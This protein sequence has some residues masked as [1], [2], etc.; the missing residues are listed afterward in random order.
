MLLWIPQ[1]S[2]VRQS[3][4]E[5]VLQVD[6]RD[7]RLLQPGDVVFISVPTAFWAVLASNW[8]LPEYR[9]GHV[10]MVSRA[11]PG[12]LAV[13]HASGNPTLANA[14]VIAVPLAEFVEGASRVDIFRPTRKSAALGSAA[15]AD[16]FARAHLAF[17]SDFSLATP[18]SLYCSELVWRA[19]SAGFGQDILPRKS[20]VAGRD[21]IL[22]RDLESSRYLR[23]VETVTARARPR[24]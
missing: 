5:R 4:P 10:G 19:L 11:G 18:R 17:D 20:R 14:K 23:L 1:S 2:C 12:R 8:S 6:A 21:A 3:Q 7:L 9:H 16:G 15:A 13:V 24:H 22:L